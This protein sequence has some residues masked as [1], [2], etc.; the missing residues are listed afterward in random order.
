VELNLVAE[1]CLGWGGKYKRDF[2]SSSPIVMVSPKP[3][4][5]DRDLQQVRWWNLAARN[6]EWSLCQI[7]SMLCLE[8]VARGLK[9]VFP[10]ATVPGMV[11]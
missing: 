8:I 10:Y 6:G 3:D 11:P 1:K 4:R 9:T 5:T 7:F 2:F